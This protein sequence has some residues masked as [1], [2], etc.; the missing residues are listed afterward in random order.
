MFERLDNFRDFGGYPTGAGRRLATG[1]LYRS[2]HHADV[3]EADLERLAA[4]GIAAYVDLR[5]PNERQRQPC[6]RPAGFQGRVIENDMEVTDNWLAFL[7]ETDEL[8]VPAYRAFIADYY[9]TAPFEPHHTDLFSRYFDA[10]AEVDGA[11]LIHCAAGKDRTGMLAALTHHMA[12]VAEADI[13]HDFLLT[14]DL[15]RIEKRLPSMGRFI[16]KITGRRTD[17]DLVRE[18][19]KVDEGDLRL[20]FEALQRRHGGPDGYLEDILGVD[21]PKREAIL[22]KLIV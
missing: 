20:T 15:D 18:M 13:V 1:R 9:A 14:N 7:T 12:G 4:L 3:T 16:E 11:I 22:S 19:L 10:L 8:T 2:A 5:R 21:R 6:R 17:P